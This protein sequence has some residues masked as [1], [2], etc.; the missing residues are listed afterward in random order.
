MDKSLDYILKLGLDTSHLK[1]A[2]AE[3]SKSLAPTLKKMEACERKRYTL[4]NKTLL[5]R[6]KEIALAKRQVAIEKQIRAAEA[7]GAKGFSRIR[8]TAGKGDVGSISEA[9][10]LLKRKLLAFETRHRSEK[11]LQAEKRETLKLQERINRAEM[12][13]N[14]DANISY[15]ARTALQERVRS[16]GT[17]SY[18]VEDPNLVSRIAKAKMEL[19]SLHKE[20]TDTKSQRALIRM[21]IRYA[22][23]QREI[24]SAVRDQKA[25]NRAMNKGNIISRKFGQS[26][27]HFA[28]HFAGAYAILGGA[29]HIYQTGKELDSMQASLLAASG[30][31][32]EAQKDFKFLEET[33]IELGK[34]LTTL[35]GGYNKVAIAGRT[36]G[37]TAEENKNIFMAASE[38]STA[39]GLSQERTNLVM[40]AFSQM[41]N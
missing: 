22:D 41:I 12:K 17:R 40:L 4:Q 27:R 18:S 36:A 10:L 9:E 26:M 5:L 19:K 14:P 2:N 31:F 33:S 21:R 34:S 35:V 25:L 24:S 16:A 28:M 1:K 37:F 29:N 38:A 13:A 11:K 39:Y 6:Q 8:G 15:Q 20:I 3:I 30:G 7:K 23:I 32:M